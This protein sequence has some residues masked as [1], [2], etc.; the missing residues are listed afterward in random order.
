MQTYSM[1]YIDGDYWLASRISSSNETWNG[2]ILYYDNVGYYQS[3][4]KP[5]A[6]LACVGK[7]NDGTNIPYLQCINILSDGINIGYVQKGVRPCITL[8]TTGVKIT[9]GDGKTELTAYTLGL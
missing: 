3:T 1:Y 5:G 9:S 6:F 2:S 7:I 4:Y 8:K